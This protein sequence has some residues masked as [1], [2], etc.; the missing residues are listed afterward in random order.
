[1]SRA[2][3]ARLGS[4]WQRQVYHRWTPATAHKHSVSQAAELSSTPVRQSSKANT[5]INFVPQQQAW[6]VERFGK[7]LRTLQP[8][9]EPLSLPSCVTCVSLLGTEYSDSS[10]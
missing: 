10:G 5:V 3:V 8:V 2:R 1:M 7:Y 4:L 9:S 6:I